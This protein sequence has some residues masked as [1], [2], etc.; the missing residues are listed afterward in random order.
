MAIERIAVC[1][2]PN[3]CNVLLGS[4]MP[5][6]NLISESSV[7]NGPISHNSFNKL[8]HVPHVPHARFPDICCDYRY[9]YGGLVHL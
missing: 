1:S 6:K 3:W 9:V 2:T 8:N 4:V 5:P 7:R